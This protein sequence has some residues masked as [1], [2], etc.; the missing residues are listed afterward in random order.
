MVKEWVKPVAFK[1]LLMIDKGTV[2][3]Q[4]FDRP[5]TEDAAPFE[6]TASVARR[7]SK[8][9]SSLQKASGV[10]LVQAV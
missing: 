5:H 1:T 6:S 4:L 10:L 9:L 3:A 7:I 2:A 8:S